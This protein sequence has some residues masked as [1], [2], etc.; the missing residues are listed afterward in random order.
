VIVQSQGG[1][2]GAA[3]GA[4]KGVKSVNKSIWAFSS[5]ALLCVGQPAIADDSIYIYC[6]AASIDNTK[7]YY[8]NIVIA[9]KSE[10]NRNVLMFKKVKFE[11]LL[12]AQN[13]KVDQRKGSCTH[14]TTSEEA[15]RILR[16]S[17]D[18]D[19]KRGAKTFSLEL[20]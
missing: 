3:P 10:L 19:E 20:S 7:I 8:S 15:N 5:I 6:R 4:K 1:G 13:I 16:E 17:K 11:Y 18:Q 9:K 2:A 14:W 12:E